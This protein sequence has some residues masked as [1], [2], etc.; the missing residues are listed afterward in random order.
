MQAADEN[1]AVG[2]FTRRH[3]PDL[4]ARGVACHVGDLADARA[5]DKALQSADVVFHVA[6]KAGMWGITVCI[7]PP[8]SW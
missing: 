6:A 4:A 5:V 3:Y 2:S 1:Y 7:M 8:M